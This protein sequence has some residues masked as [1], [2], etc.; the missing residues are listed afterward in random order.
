MNIVEPKRLSLSDDGIFPNSKYPVLLYHNSFEKDGDDLANWLIKR[1]NQ[2]GWSEAWKNDIYPFHHYHSTAHEVLGVYSGSG[3]LLLGG[4]RGERIH[5][6][7]GDIL[8]LPAGVAHKCLDD[9]ELKVVGAYADG[10]EWDINRGERGERP[11]TDQNKA[12]L[13]LPKSDPLHGNQGVPQLW[14]NDLN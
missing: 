2:H 7:K 1:F 10:R 9:Q 11:Q 12:A 8:I 4:E 5:V 13:P 6:K 14:T 3:L